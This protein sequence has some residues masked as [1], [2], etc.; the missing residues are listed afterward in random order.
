[1]ASSPVPADG[2]STT[3]AGVIAAA[4]LATKPS[5]IGVRELLERLALFGTAG[6]GRKKAGDLGQHRQHGGWR[7]GRARMAGPNLRR[8]RTVA[9][10]QAS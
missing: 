7:C 10:S 2:S 8:N 1:M 3:S 6:M 9:A 5:G 4:V